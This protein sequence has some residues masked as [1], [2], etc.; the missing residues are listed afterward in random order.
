MWRCQPVCKWLGRLFEQVPRTVHCAVNHITLHL[1]SI[2]RRVSCSAGVPSVRN[3]DN[4]ACCDGNSCGSTSYC[5]GS[6]VWGWIIIIFCCCCYA[7]IAFLI[8]RCATGAAQPGGH[9]VQQAP[10]NM[11]Q[12]QTY[13]QPY[14]VQVQPGYGA[15]APAPPY[16]A[17]PPHTYGGQAPAP[18][19]T[20]T[21]P[22]SGKTYWYND[23]G[24]TTWEDPCIG[25]QRF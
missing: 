10:S 4:G 1:L 18:W 20:A 12:A 7:G 6:A 11:A 14:Q 8:F 21:D 23:A 13:Q 2:P 24:E 25:G 15:P 17:P 19:Q 5:D 16:G 9:V 3:S 22:S